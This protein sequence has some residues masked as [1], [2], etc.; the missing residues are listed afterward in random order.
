[1][2]SFL[3]KYK[4]YIYIVLFLIILVTVFLLVKNFLYPDDMISIYGSRL[5]GIEK[6]KITNYRKN[7]IK[8]IFLEEELVESID[9]DV[10]GKIINIII[11]GKEKYTIEEAKKKITEGI[12]SLKKEEIEFYDVQFFVTN[13]NIKY[14]LIGYKNKNS[15]KISWTEHSEVTDEE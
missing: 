11:K 5:E 8:G 13:E 3:K 1:M 14:T 9:I 2:I 4:V 7:E 15:E 6:V 12:K 10:K